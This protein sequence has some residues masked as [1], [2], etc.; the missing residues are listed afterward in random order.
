MGWL[1]PHTCLFVLLASVSQPLQA[2]AVGAIP[3]DATGN[4]I[5]RND[6]GGNTTY[7]HATHTSALTGEQASGKNVEYGYYGG[8]RY[9]DEDTAAG[10]PNERLYLYSDDNLLYAMLAVHPNGTGSPEDEVPST[11]DRR[12]STLDP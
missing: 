11:V 9:F 5:A 3:H 1:R 10:S 12:P 6:S 2:S 8:V 4:R 7:S